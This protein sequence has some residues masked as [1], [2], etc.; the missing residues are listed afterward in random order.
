SSSAVVVVLCRFCLCFSGGHRDLLSFPTRRSSD[1]TGWVYADLLM[2]MAIG[3]VILPRAV[4]LGVRAGRILVQAAPAG[5]DVS[6]LRR[7][8]LE[9]DGVIDVHDLHVWTLTSEMDVASV[10]LMIPDDS[11]P[12]PVLDR[13]RQV[14]RDDHGISHAT[15]QVE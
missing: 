1:L 2:G 3:L 15:L 5:F 12:H 11:D 6:G 8:L 4:R 13:A 7:Q 9:L 10:H 14:L